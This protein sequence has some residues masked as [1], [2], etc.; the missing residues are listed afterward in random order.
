MAKIKASF[1]QLP[2]NFYI[3]LASRLKEKLF[4]D[5]QLIDAVN[6]V[7]DTCVYPV[8]TIA[9]FLSFNKKIRLFT[10]QEMLK[11]VH[12][13]GGDPGIWDYHDKKKIEGITFWYLKSEYEI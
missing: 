8:P 4:S 5:Q 2:P 6:N 12:D 1:S 10:Y 11:K 7:I 3:I 13:S 9:N